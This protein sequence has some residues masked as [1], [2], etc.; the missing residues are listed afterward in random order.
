MKATP[1][2]SSVTMITACGS[3]FAIA[4]TASSTFTVPRAW[5]ATTT[6]VRLCCFIAFSV[7]VRPSL[8]NESSV[9]N[10]ATRLIPVETSCDT[11]FAVS[12]W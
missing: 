4:A 9:W 6:G 10:T 5:L 1:A 11:I 2:S 12:E 7:P 8:P 3:A